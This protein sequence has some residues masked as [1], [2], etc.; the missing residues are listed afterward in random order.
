[1]GSAE[2]DV[3]ECGQG[4]RFATEDSTRKLHEVLI[5]GV[6]KWVQSLAFLAT[7]APLLFNQG[8]N[9]S[10]LSLASCARMFTFVPMGSL[11]LPPSFPLSPSLL[12][13]LPPSLPL[14]LAIHV[15]LSL[16]HL[17]AIETHEQDALARRHARTLGRPCGR[18]IPGADVCIYLHSLGEARLKGAPFNIRCVRAFCTSV[19]TSTAPL[20]GRAAGDGLSHPFPLSVRGKV[21][22][23]SL[24]L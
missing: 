24:G 11:S 21:G 19:S 6:I 12:L 16:S 17:G 4:Q 14:Y 22:S 9:F 7:T 15:S 13:S 10:S 5:L 18:R 3:C 2:L 20:P 1:M 8:T 23:S